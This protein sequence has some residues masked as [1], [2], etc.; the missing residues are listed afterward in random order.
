MGWSVLVQDKIWKKWEFFREDKSSEYMLFISPTH[1]RV[2][3]ENSISSTGT[4]PT[5]LG[6]VGRCTGPRSGSLIICSDSCFAGFYCFYISKVL[7]SCWCC[8]LVLI[9][10]FEHRL[11]CGILWFTQARMLW[12][13]LYRL[14]ACKFLVIF[15][16]A[17]NNSFYFKIYI[18][19]LQVFESSSKICYMWVNYLQVFDF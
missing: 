15:K 11:P 18:S 4:W 7:I 3:R 16:E 13:C 9:F 6:R 8:I 14:C 5:K 12:L 2:K 19:D 17:V 1:L 10:I